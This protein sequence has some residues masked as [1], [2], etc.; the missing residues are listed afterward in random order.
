MVL[1]DHGERAAREHERHAAELEGRARTHDDCGLR[2]VLR[3][4]Q[5]RKSHFVVRRQEAFQREAFQ[6]VLE[7]IAR[8]RFE[9]HGKSLFV[10]RGIERYGVARPVTSIV[11]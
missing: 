7:R 2:E 8:K 9:I 4:R 10:F 1:D 11:N 6:Q 5:D 3:D